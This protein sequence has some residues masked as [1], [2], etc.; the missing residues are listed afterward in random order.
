MKIV[1][2]FTGYVETMPVKTGDETWK[3]GARVE[4][5]SAGSLIEFAR[6]KDANSPS[7]A[8]YEASKEIAEVFSDRRPS[9]ADDDSITYEIVI[10]WEAVED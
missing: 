1:H 6:V 4:Y 9:R 10:H 3:Y 5:D 2:H 7:E 8:V